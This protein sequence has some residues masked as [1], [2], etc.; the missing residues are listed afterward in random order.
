MSDVEF[1][2]DG[3]AVKT[4]LATLKKILENYLFE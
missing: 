3:A 1:I 4:D 2:A